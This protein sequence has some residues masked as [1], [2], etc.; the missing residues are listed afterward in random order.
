LLNRLAIND[1]RNVQPIVPTAGP[2]AVLMPSVTADFCLN[3]TIAKVSKIKEMLNIWRALSYPIPTAVPQLDFFNTPISSLL[4][5]AG[6]RTFANFLS[7]N[8]LS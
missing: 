2:R 3:I 8:Y 5:C 4:I 1:L 6:C 7:L